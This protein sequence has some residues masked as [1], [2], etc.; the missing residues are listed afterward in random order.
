MKSQEDC[1][2]P[3]Y[4]QNT[5]RGIKYTKKGLPPKIKLRM[6]HVQSTKFFSS[7]WTTLCNDLNQGGE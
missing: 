6:F 7:T 5:I 3:G 4:C 1:L 2:E